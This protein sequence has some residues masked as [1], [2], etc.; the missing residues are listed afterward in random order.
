MYYNTIIIYGVIQA[1][2][3]LAGCSTETTVG[4]KI[5]AVVHVKI[6]AKRKLLTTINGR[7]NK[8]RRIIRKVYTHILTSSNVLTHK[9]VYVGGLIALSHSHCKSKGR[10]TPITIPPSFYLSPPASRPVHGGV[11]RK[12]VMGVQPLYWIF[13]NFWVVCLQNILSKPCSYTD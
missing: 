4:M 1:S 2:S 3:Y 7:R 13:R 12:G 11:F 8:T 6:M 9:K 5:A 10:A